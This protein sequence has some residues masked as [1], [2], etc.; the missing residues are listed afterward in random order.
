MSVKYVKIKAP[1]TGFQSYR[2]IIRESI[3]LC[4]GDFRG[5]HTNQAY[6]GKSLILEKGLHFSDDCVIP[7]PLFRQ[8]D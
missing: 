3:R 1:V 2:T 6:Y 4:W 7:V 5:H 8:V